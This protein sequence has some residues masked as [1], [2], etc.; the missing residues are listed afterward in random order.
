M[1]T[2]TDSQPSDSVEAQQGDDGDCVSRLVRHVCYDCG[3]GR[4]IAYTAQSWSGPCYICRRPIFC[5]RILTDKCL[6]CGDTGRVWNA[7]D[8]REEDC[9]NC[10]P[11][12]Q[13]QP[14]GG[15]DVNLRVRRC[16]V[17][18]RGPVASAPAPDYQA[19]CETLHSG[20]RLC[21]GTA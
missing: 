19:E 20:E 6:T 17:R 18:R 16:L 14:T 12:D 10:L 11:H 21:D 4:G 1:N 3:K 2:K 9:K 15:Q 8:E 7:P 5:D 13:G